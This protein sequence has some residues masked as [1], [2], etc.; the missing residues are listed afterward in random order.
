MIFIV[1]FGYVS[2]STSKFVNADDGDDID[3]NPDGFDEGTKKNFERIVTIDNDGSSVKMVSKLKNSDDK[4]EFSIDIT[5]NNEL[6]FKGLYKSHTDN[7]HINLEFQLRFYTIIEYIDTDNDGAYTDDFDSYIGEYDIDEF[8]PIEYTTG[9]AHIL[10]IQTSDDVFLARIFAVEG[11]TD[12]NGIIVTSMEVKIDFEIHNFPF[13]E[14]ESRLALLVHFQTNAAYGWNEKSYAEQQGYED[15]ETELEMK[16]REAKGYFSWANTA[17]A[18]GQEVEVT[19]NS[20]KE[21][22][23]VK[24][25]YLN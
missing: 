4:D 7:N 17:T 2:V 3:P 19:G 18:D 13:T 11:I 24:K 8:L 6:S 20:L 25:I 9:N 21:S 23:N 1:V 22:G 10:V 16:N 5:T 15:D 12:I 14:S